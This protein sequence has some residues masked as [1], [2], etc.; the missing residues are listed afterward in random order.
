MAESGVGQ[1]KNCGSQVPF[2][3]SQSAYIASQSAF[4]GG[5]KRGFGSFCDKYRCK[6][7]ESNDFTIPFLGIFTTK[8][9]RSIDTQK[10]RDTDAHGKTAK[11]AGR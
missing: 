9:P 10:P 1:L 7:F 11:L 4:L 2:L 5:I 3:L 6:S 8:T